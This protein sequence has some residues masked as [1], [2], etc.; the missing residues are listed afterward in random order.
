ML[1]ILPT[2][3]FKLM[4]SL[5]VHLRSVFEAWEPDFGR[6]FVP[7]CDDPVKKRL[8]DSLEPVVSRQGKILIQS[9]YD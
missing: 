3:L 1:K 5:F 6:T 7:W 9:G 8:R 2:S 4:T